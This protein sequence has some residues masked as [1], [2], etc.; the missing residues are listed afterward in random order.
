MSFRKRALASL[1]SVAMVWS[2]TPV[3]AI[4]YA[5][6][7]IVA[8][9]AAVVEVP[10]DEG[11]DPSDTGSTNQGNTDGSDDQGQP[12][13]GAEDGTGAEGDGGSDG[14][15]SETTD[16]VTPVDDVTTDGVV[17]DETSTDEVVEEDPEAADKQDEAT[18]AEKAEDE[19]KAEDAK[20]DEQQVK[21]AAPS[22]TPGLSVQAHVQNVG[23]QKAVTSG[24][25]AGTSGRS[26][27]VEGLKI[28]ITG[29]KTKIPSGS[30]EYRT[31]VENIGW[32]D[33]V[34]D[35]ALAG[36]SGQSLRIEAMQI[37]LTG[38][39]ADQYDVYYQVH[40]QNEGWMAVASNG[41]LTGTSGKAYRLE[42]LR[43]WLVKKGGAAPNPATD[44][45]KT[46]D[47][48]QGLKGT[49]HVQ[50]VG[51]MG[52]VGNGKVVGTTG[53]GLRLEA[54][55]LA[56]EGVEIGGDIRY[57]AHVQNIGWQ[58]WKKNGGIAGSV[59][60][61]L[62][63]EAIEIDLTGDLESTY[64]VYYR[65]HVSNVGWLAWAKEGETAGSTGMSQRVEAIQ[66]KLVK[67]GG[68]APSNDDAAYKEPCIKSVTL[69]YS[70]KVQGDSSWQGWKKNGQT[71][72]STGKGLRITGLRA[73]ISGESG[74]IAYEFGVQDQADKGWVSGSA[75]KNGADCLDNGKRVEIVRL[76]LSGTVA[77]TYDVYYRAHVQNIG[78]TGWG[79][80]GQSVGSKELAYRIE[81]IQ[82]KLVPKGGSAPGSTA[83][84]LYDKNGTHYDIF[85]KAQ[86]YSSSTGYLLLVD[87]NNCWVGVFT[88]SRGNW[89]PKYYWRCSCGKDS[90]PTVKGVFTT[91]TSSLH[92]GEEHGYT[93]W[94]ATQIYG[95]YLFHSVKYQPGSQTA[96][97]DGRL[98]RHISMGCVRLPIEDAK[99]I[100]YNI[101]DGTTVVTY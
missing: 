9:D 38:E 73:T 3:G 95:D 31:H 34:K 76:R 30:I 12:T 98:G 72:G 21:L 23:W 13:D 49:A 20:K 17:V 40:A 39:L 28:S 6:D 74:N 65:T 26:L 77:T 43:V 75:V 97:K 93:C 11:G 89:N 63:I 66:V 54:F 22:A 35:G 87:T 46:F 69:Q 36:T 32:Q 90:S 41:E 92:F 56:M 68:A 84:H 71:A 80:N 57:R 19:K 1:L 16:E 7:D 47:G 91:Q 60:R 42:A 29:D 101:P 64:D 4:A 81:A 55:K 70:V 50:N 61:G 37:R 48:I 8:D 86:G 14:T 45:T 62:R 85:K 24:K 79:K 78:W 18:D 27:R 96:L 33:W 15:S 2:L 25:T 82:V 67:K 51:W 83:Y 44:T 94:Y 52:S 99:W 88:G 10:L 53:R 100:Y 59:G 5:D 58:G